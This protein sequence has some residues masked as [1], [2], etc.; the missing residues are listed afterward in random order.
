MMVIP[1]QFIDKFVM[2]YAVEITDPDINVL[3]GDLALATQH[4]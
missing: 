4:P 1:S 2:G 3:Q